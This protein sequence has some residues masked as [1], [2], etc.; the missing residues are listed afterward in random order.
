MEM[1]IKYLLIGLLVF[2]GLIF[3]NQ[4]LAKESLLATKEAPLSIELVSYP[5]TTRVG[6][7]STI[8]WR[9]NATNDLST[10]FSTLYW[11]NSPSP[12]SY[13][14]H[15]S[16]YTSGRFSLPYN[17]ESSLSFDQPQTVYFRAYAKVRDQD[18]W[19][20]EKQFIVLP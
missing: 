1:S 11:S 10:D 18:L 4:N 2:L 12:K 5:E 14:R 8:I 17:F 19:S 9:V 20:E 7:H 16:D 6:N 3:Y 15:V 13:E